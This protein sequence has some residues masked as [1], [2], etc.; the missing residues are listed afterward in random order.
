MISEIDVRDLNAITIPD[1]VDS[2][3]PHSTLIEQI[4]IVLSQRKHIN[5]QQNSATNHVNNSPKRA[6]RPSTAKQSGSPPKRVRMMDAAAP[7]SNPKTP[8]A[9]PNSR[10]GSMATR[11]AAAAPYH[12]FLT[13]IDDSKETHSQ[14]LSISF[15]D[16]QHLAWFLLTSAN[17][18][19]AAWGRT[20]HRG[21]G[22]NIMSYEAG[23]LFLPKL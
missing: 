14:G 22:Q 1:N 12:F 21:E 23:V 6:V 19:K 20:T 7:A 9:P 16:G 11:W 2:T 18:S 4:K 15:P 3:L 10:A 8:V 13:Q 17:L 5:R